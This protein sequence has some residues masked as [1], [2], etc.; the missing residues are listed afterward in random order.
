MHDDDRAIRDLVSTYCHAIA[1]RDDSTWA[2]TWAEDGEWVVLGSTVRGRDAILAHYR[3]LVSGM[4]WVV[5][6]A[7]NGIVEVDGNAGRGRWQIVEYLQG[8]GGRGGVNIARYRD[9]YVRGSDG[10]WRFARRELLATY[11]GAA[12]LSAAPQR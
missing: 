10:K 6:H 11:L 2:S 5:Q 9:D 1:E 7:N 8:G 3:K 4:R 12:D